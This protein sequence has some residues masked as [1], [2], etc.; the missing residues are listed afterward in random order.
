MLTPPSPAVRLSVCPLLIVEEKVIA[1]PFVVIEAGPVSAAAPPTEKLAA[2][3]AFWIVAPRFAAPVTDIAF[4]FI[5]MMPA[6]C[7]NMPP[8]VS[9]AGPFRVTAGFNPELLFTVRFVTVELVKSTVCSTVPFSVIVPVEV[10][11]PPA[12]VM[13][14][15]TNN[16]NPPIERVPEVKATVPNAFPLPTAPP[17]ITDPAAPVATVN[18]CAPTA[19]ASIVELSV[20]LAPPVVKVVAPPRVTGPVSP[21]AAAVV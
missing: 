6:L 1:P 7:V 12:W 3:P 15:A 16:P 2:A 19:V 4:P 14:P 18:P 17:A 9:V 8:T 20:T 13:F 5:L 10:I 11:L 21:I